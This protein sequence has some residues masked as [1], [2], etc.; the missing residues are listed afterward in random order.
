MSDF[1]DKE[2]AALDDYYPG[3]RRKRRTPLPPEVQPKSDW[4][5]RAVKKILPNGKEVE[6]F[7]LG[8]L[9]DALGRPIITL[10][11]WMKEGHLP[12]SPYRLPDKK[13]KNGDVRK[14]RRLYTR[15]MIEAAIS[16]FERA[17]LLY[18]KRVQWSVHRQVTRDID[19][20]W[21]KIRAEETGN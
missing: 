1:I 13:D 11:L 21:T 12:A 19:E 2:F 16:A 9:A 18:T 10:R 20:A 14:G 15:S 3:S 5:Q 7:T 6:M 4:D 17:G 8:A